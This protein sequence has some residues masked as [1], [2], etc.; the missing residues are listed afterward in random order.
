MIA[1]LFLDASGVRTILWS[2]RGLGPPRFLGIA[3]LAFACASASAL[4]RTTFGEGR[5]AVS[6]GVGDLEQ[7]SLHEERESDLPSLA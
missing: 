6:G 4:T 2:P 1:V 5:A 7:S 3:G